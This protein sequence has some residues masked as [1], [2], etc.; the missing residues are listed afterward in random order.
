MNEPNITETNLKAAL[1]SVE[2]ASG[3]AMCDRHGVR[4]SRLRADLAYA[5][6]RCIALGI[7]AETE[8]DLHEVLMADKCRTISWMFLG[9]FAV[10]VIA[11]YLVFRV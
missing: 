1:E 7:M 4:E 5:Q 8:R 9:L 11:A 6:H 3:C 2:R 10:G